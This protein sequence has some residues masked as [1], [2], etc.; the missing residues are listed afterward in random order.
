MRSQYINIGLFW[1]MLFI[2]TSSNSLLW[3]WMKAF[4]Y[5]L[6]R[7]GDSVCI[8][9]GVMPSEKSQLY[10]MRQAQLHQIKAAELQSNHKI[11][12]YHLV[13]SKGLYFCVQTTHD[14]TAHKHIWPIRLYKLCQVDQRR[15]QES[16]LSRDTQLLAFCR[17]M[18]HE[19]SQLDK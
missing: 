17:F 9:L 10:Q 19:K 7:D 3:D 4:C 16:V 2:H 12:K 1:F 8:F 5:G 14:N 11:T 13:Y 6:W 15:W 18:P